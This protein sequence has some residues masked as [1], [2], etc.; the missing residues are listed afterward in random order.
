MMPSPTLPG[1]LL[2]NA[3]AHAAKPAFRHR[4]RGIWHTLSWSGFAAMV[5]RCALGLAAHGFG[6]G[7]R[8]ALIGE[9]EPRSHAALLAAQCL[10]GI[11]LPLDPDA[12]PAM[13]EH[14]LRQADA[15]FLLVDR[16]EQAEVARALAP[17][18]LVVC[19]QDHPDVMSFAALVA[20]GEAVTHQRPRSFEDE[21]AQ[22]LPADSAVLLAHGPRLIELSHARLL[23]AAQSLASQER[24]GAAD[25]AFCYQPLSALGELVYSLTLGL[26]CGFCCNCPERP[27]TVPRDLREIG[28]T[29]LLAPPRALDLLVADMARRLGNSSGIRRRAFQGFRAAAMHATELRE[30]RSRVSLPL[31]LSCAIGALVIDAPVRDLLGLSRARFIHVGPGTPTPDTAI[32]F[33]SLGLTLRPAVL[34]DPAELPFR[35]A[36]EPSHV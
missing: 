24:I 25:E 13:L 9:N 33:R 10:G 6:P 1:L 4:H 29:F 2:R 16:P 23:S 3:A 36:R 19:K 15:S 32:L 20:T 21:A 31:R 11:T 18:G 7:A 17:P 30:Q 27:D 5:H 8:L 35:A 34:V 14:W 28:P 12:D 22:P 26:H